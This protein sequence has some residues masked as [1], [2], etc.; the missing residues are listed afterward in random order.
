M[1]KQ[2][3]VLKLCFSFHFHFILPKQE[4]CACHM[5]QDS[6]KYNSKNSTGV[7]SLISMIV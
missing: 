6:V 3:W 5:Q 1:V 7:Q 4:A 2:S